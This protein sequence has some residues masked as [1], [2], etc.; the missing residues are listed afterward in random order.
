[1]TTLKQMDS[2]T[3]LQRH[4]VQFEAMQQQHRMQLDNVQKQ[5]KMQLESLKHRHKL[6]LQA[7]SA[8]QQPK[9]D[10]VA[11]E[12]PLTVNRPPTKKPVASTITRPPPTPKDFNLSPITVTCPDSLP[13]F[14]GWFEFEHD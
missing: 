12:Y 11:V 14:I 4:S 5:Q 2:D 3:V 6:E 10:L 8:R 13:H 7:F 1:M 9:T